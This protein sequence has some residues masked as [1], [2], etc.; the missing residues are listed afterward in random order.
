VPHSTQ[1]D[2][3]QTA[4]STP[5]SETG[6]RVVG[7][8]HLLVRCSHW[9]NVPILLVPYP[10]WHVHLLGISGLSAQTRSTNR[11]CRFSCGRR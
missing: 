11:K 7:R 3:E 10:K 8:H 2:N 9:L 5:E 4:T 6:V 1:L